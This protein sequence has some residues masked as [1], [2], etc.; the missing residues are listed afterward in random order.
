MNI[1]KDLNVIYS[2]STEGY[3]NETLDLY[4]DDKLYDSLK[5]SAGLKG[6]ATTQILITGYGKGQ[7]YQEEVP[8]L[9]D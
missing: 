5:I 9:T 6:K 3:L 4:L 2:G 1:T 7:T 8:D